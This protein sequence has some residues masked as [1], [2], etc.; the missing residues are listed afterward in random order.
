MTLTNSIEG[1]DITTEIMEED[2]EHLFFFAF[3]EGVFSDPTGDGNIDNRADAVNYKDVDENGFPVGLSTNWTTQA[4]MGGGEFRVVLKHQPGIK[5]A[6]STTDDGGTDVDL[7]FTL[8]T[9]TNV[10][11]LRDALRQQ[12]TLAPNPTQ[13]QLNWTLDGQPG[14]DQLE[15]R[16]LSI[17]GQVMQLHTSQS[18]IIDVSRLPAGT[19]IFQLQTDQAIVSKRF[20]KAN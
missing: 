7:T 19:Y 11:D 12:L 10:N 18:P 15:V 4:S 6:T 13:H 8:N 3:A 20:I 16:I 5:S 2:D 9:V 1:E 17:T 14:G